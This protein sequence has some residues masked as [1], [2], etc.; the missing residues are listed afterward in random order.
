[1]YVY[2]CIYI[3]EMINKPELSPTPLGARTLC[4]SSWP[5]RF[6]ARSSGSHHPAPGSQQQN[7]LSSGTARAPGLQSGLTASRR[8]KRREK[9][10]AKNEGG[11]RDAGSLPAACGGAGA[12]GIPGKLPAQEGRLPV[13]VAAGESRRL[14]HGLFL[15]A[16]GNHQRPGDAP[17]TDPG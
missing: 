5:C 7:P 17:S 9:H 6:P 12:A 10:G 16:A 4:I 13:L 14:L 8:R 1:M 11:E 15:S 2:I 3:S